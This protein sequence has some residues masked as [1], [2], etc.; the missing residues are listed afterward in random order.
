MIALIRPRLNPTASPF[1]SV[2][3]ADGDFKGERRSNATHA[4]CTDSQAKLMRKGNGQPVKLSTVRM[5]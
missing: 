4:S 2:R 3:C 5:R 1:L